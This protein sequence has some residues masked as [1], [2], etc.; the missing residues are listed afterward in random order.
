MLLAPFDCVC[1]QQH[2]FDGRVWALPIT[3]NRS[4][5]QSAQHAPTARSIRSGRTCAINRSTVEPLRRS[6]PPHRAAGGWGTIRGG[7]A[8]DEMMMGSSRRCDAPV[9]SN[10]N[11]DVGPPVPM[12]GSRFEKLQYVDR[13]GSIG[14]R[15]KG[16]N[17]KHRR[18]HGQ[19]KRRGRAS[20]GSSERERG[21]HPCRVRRSGAR[22]S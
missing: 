18:T 21:L 20:F 13:F 6:K 2:L 12:C 1:W 3:P 5:A 11:L 9:R 16:S 4:P 14:P 17:R 22:G 7:W 8:V 19:A 15:L 10:R